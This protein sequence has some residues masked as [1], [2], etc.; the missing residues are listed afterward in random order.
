MAQT[1]QRRIAAKQV[2]QDNDGNQDAPKAA[3][4][5]VRYAETKLVK[6]MRE[7]Y[8]KAEKRAMRSSRAYRYANL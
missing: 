3:K 2:L 6:D 1:T 7:N 5:K 4:I 8:E